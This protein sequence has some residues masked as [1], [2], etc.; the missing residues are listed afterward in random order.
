MRIKNIITWGLVLATFLIVG[1]IAASCSNPDQRPLGGI[2]PPFD[3]PLTKSPVG[4]II[5][6]PVFRQVQPDPLIEE[7]YEAANLTPLTTTNLWNY[8]SGAVSSI[9]IVGTKV[10][11]ANMVSRLVSAA[12]SGVIVEILV[13][14]GYFT[15]P[16]ASPFIAQ[17]AQSGNVTIRTDNDGIARQVHSAFAIIDN[18]MVLA[19]SGD[20]LDD[21]FNR[22]INN[23]TV[24]D[25]PGT[26][27]N[28]T[29]P[30]GVKTLT[31]AFLFEFDQMFN[32]GKFGG[33]KDRLINHTFNVGVEVEVYFGPNDNLQAEIIDEVNNMSS[34]LTYMVNQVSDTTILSVLANFAD[35]GF[36]EFT[37]NPDYSDILTTSTPFFWPSYN[38]LNHKIMIIDVPVQIGT[39]FS[40]TLLGLLDPVVITGSNNWTQPGLKLN[41]EQMVVIHDVTM[42]YEIGFIEYEVLNR[43]ANGIGVVFGHM[44]TSKNVAIEGAQIT[45]DSES[46]A[47][48]VFPGDGGEPTEGMSTMRG[49]YFM[50]VP[51]GFVRNIQVLSLGDA[52]GLYLLPEVIW[53]EEQPNS[54]YNLLPGA[55][56]KLNFYVR[57]V[58]SQTGTGSGGGGG[59][60]GF[61]P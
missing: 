5:S 2:F 14:K 26:Y 17:L 40:T 11:N 20:L 22:S 29:G 55:S 15:E 7:R 61:G 23:V 51:T 56:Y 49:T 25:T 30:G 12:N 31:D 60:G 8:F 27:I 59:G 37:S 50:F 1:G 52:S 44:K 4:L 28:G 9:K 46:M 58:P 32:M 48:G 19:S 39:D 16:D 47:G 34:N 43:E 24:Y 45:C 57:P 33:E 10:T 3:F 13:E 21:T 18:H 54:G 42:G 36:Y 6:D 41:D 35:G 38:T 53:G